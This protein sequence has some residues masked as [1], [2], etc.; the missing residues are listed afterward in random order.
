MDLG[1]SDRKALNFPDPDGLSAIFLYGADQG[2]THD[3]A[4]SLLD[5]CAS[6][7]VL[8]APTLSRNSAP[9]V[10]QLAKEDLLGSRSGLLVTN[11]TDRH[12]GD[13]S[14]LLD[15]IESTRGLLIV[16]EAPRRPQ[17]TAPERLIA[18]FRASSRIASFELSLLPSKRKMAF[19]VEA[20]QD[21]EMKVSRGAAE[22]LASRL[23]GDRGQARRAVEVAALHARSRASQVIE[24]GDVIA[25]MPKVDETDLHAPLDAA[26]Q[27]GLAEGFDQL[28]RRAAR[29]ERPLEIL[30][31]FQRRVLRLRATRKSV[32]T[33]QTTA[34]RAIATYAASDRPAVK[35]IV[36]KTPL[37][38]F[39]RALA[40]LDLAETRIIVHHRL[41]EIEISSAIEDIHL[42]AGGAR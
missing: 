34:S 27:G 15:I 41:A 22:S 28:A 1:A 23:P 13:V 32:E 17:A 37:I 18:C 24:A 4:I 31:S 40:R 30:R 29:G 9:A 14:A 21:I 6:R 35:Y 16:T 2:G 33:Q 12:E 36:E 20:A 25:V 38:T 19:A 7:L 3:L 8:E 42:L 39:D 5:K 10:R 26:F 11:A